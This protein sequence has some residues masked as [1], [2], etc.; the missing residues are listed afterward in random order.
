MN[1][2]VQT[3][4]RPNTS[5]GDGPGPEELPPLPFV[6]GARE[7]DRIFHDETTALAASS[8]TQ[9]G[10][11]PVVA[12]GF[13]RH[14]KYEVTLSGGDGT[15]TA[16]VATDRGIWRV[17]E[18]LRLTDQDGKSLADVRGFE[19]YLANKYG[20]V[21]PGLPDPASWPSYSA[22]DANGDGTFILRVPVEVSGRDAFGA[23]AN[24]SSSN[25]FQHEYTIAA[26]GDLFATSPAPTLPSVRVKASLEYWHPPRSTGPGGR[27]ISQAPPA[28]GSVRMI[29]SMPF[30]VEAGAQE[31]RLTRLGNHYQVLIAY[32][33]DASGDLDQA[34]LP[35][36]IELSYD[37]QQVERLSLSAHRARTAARYGLDAASGSP[38]GLDPGVLVWEWD[39]D[40]DGIPGYSTR[41]QY[42]ATTTATDL[43]I[44]GENFGAGKLFI[45][46]LDVAP[47]GQWVGV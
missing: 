20:G 11:N 34:G 5:N 1:G 33:V 28:H 2:T 13:L 39:H 37:H 17:F 25:T 41:R 35:D 27:R 15:T 47:Q 10:P 26:A 38:G 23:L 3:P 45:V 7:G 32:K 22:L 14:I 46:T 24:Q 18:R 44:I 36:P 40:L 43:R 31:Y 16:A 4:T 19:A 29:N 8:T 9:V 12:A 21:T 42:M 6:S 30:D